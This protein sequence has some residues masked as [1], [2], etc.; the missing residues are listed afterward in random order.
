MLKIAD[1]HHKLLESTFFVSTLKLI[2]LSSTKSCSRSRFE[3][4]G[5][6]IKLADTLYFTTVTET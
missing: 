2:F 3:I 1:I 6:R 5:Q 4:A